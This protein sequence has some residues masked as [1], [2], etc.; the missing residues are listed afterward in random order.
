MISELPF[1]LR[2]QFLILFQEY[3]LT[4]SVY[5][6][7]RALLTQLAYDWME[8]SESADGEVKKGRRFF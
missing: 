7:S 3:N 4:A 6:V 8:L 2:V 5:D 1:P